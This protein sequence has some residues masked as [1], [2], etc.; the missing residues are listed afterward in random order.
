LEYLL[1]LDH[2][3]ENP[4]F[5]LLPTLFFGILLKRFELV[6]DSVSP[7]YTCKTAYS[8][9]PDENADEAQQP[10]S[11]GETHLSQQVNRSD[12]ELHTKWSE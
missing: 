3:R 7:V 2:D 4:P 8:C 10:V 1:H 9:D 6:I 12:S 11:P 5:Y